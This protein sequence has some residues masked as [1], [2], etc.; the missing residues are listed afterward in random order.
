VNSDN[1]RDIQSVDKNAGRVDARSSFKKALQ[2]AGL[3]KSKVDKAWSKL[4]KSESKERKTGIKNK[5]K[6]AESKLSFQNRMKLKAKRGK[7]AL[8][9]FFN[10]KEKR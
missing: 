6:E 2:K 5:Q 3:F 8:S 9:N 7:K 4:V 10:K 1:T